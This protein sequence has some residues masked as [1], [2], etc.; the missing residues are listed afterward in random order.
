MSELNANALAVG[1]DKQPLIKEISLSVK[2]GKI[3]VII[4]PNG[5]GKSTILKTLAGN[6]DPLEGLVYLNQKP[7]EEFAATERAKQVSVMMT[8]RTNT[9][10]ASCFDVVSVGRYPFTGISGKLSKK[11]FK[12]IDEAMEMVRATELK[13]RD[14]MKISDG[15]KQRVLLA[16]ALAQNPGIMI[17]DEPTGFLDIGYK[18]EF[19]ELLRKLASEKGIGILVSMHELELAKVLADTVV[20][21]SSKGCID[22]MGTPEEIFRED[23]LEE[24]FSVPKG[25]LKKVYP[26]I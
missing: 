25:M 17:L 1:Y 26:H 24:L 5:A 3:V 7:M 6:L 14:F 2:D 10:Y 21:V 23:Y 18:L 11:D 22:R 15:Q 9:E 16:R 8:Q 20:C 12:A 4:G 13:D 19:I